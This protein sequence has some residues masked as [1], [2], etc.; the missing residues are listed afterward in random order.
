MRLYL[1]LCYFRFSVTWPKSEE[2]VIR[3]YC[4]IV[5]PEDFSPSPLDSLVSLIKKGCFQAHALL[6]FTDDRSHLQGRIHPSVVSSKTTYSSL[7]HHLF[8]HLP[9]SYILSLS[10]SQ[11]QVGRH[12][13]KHHLY[14][15]IPSIS[16]CTVP[17][18]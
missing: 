7:G 1:L 16:E 4:F 3:S 15:Q 17:Y 6:I 13:E 12:D 11:H 5:L 9:T 18:R 14:S 10:N 2:T 8:S